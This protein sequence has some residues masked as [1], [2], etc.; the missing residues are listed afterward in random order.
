MKIKNIKNDQLFIKVIC[1]IT[2]VVLWVLVM[3]DTNPVLE[4]SVVNVPVTI[5]NISAL[6]KSNMV[7]MNSDKDH[8]TV[9]VKVKGYGEQ[10]NKIDKDDFTAFI[11][12]LG[13]TEGTK[14]AQVQISGPNGVEIEDIYPA[15]IACKIK[16]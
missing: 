1:L 5:K 13:F 15:Q 8:M 9:T 16:A 2:S 4:K 10:L 7:L 14:N 6:E 3:V 12:V 11:D